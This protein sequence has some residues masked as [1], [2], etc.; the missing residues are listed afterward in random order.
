MY[1]RVI[2]DI[3]SSNVDKIF[4]YIA[5]DDI[6]IGSRVKVPFGNR[7]IEGYV[8]DLSSDTDVD[9]T[10]L[11]HISEILDSYSII[12]DEQMQ[13][14]AFMKEKYNDGYSDTFR[15]FLPSEVRN[16]KVN[17]IF[18]SKSALSTNLSIEYMLNSLKKNASSMKNAL[19][20][21]SENG[22]INT[23]ILNKKFGY[24]AIKKLVQL[25]YIKQFIE[26]IDRIP[27]KNITKKQDNE[28]VLSERQKY[29]IDT[30]I[31]N[32]SNSFLIH[33]ITGSGKTEVY[34]NVIE[35]VRKI[36]KTAIMLVPEISL[37]PQV[38]MLFRNR[39]G[40][41][42]AII[43]SGL[44]SG[45]RYD[46]W[47]R[48]L[49]GRANIVVGAR[50]AIFAPLTNLGIIIID[51]EHDS[52]YVS[53]TNP[54][55][56]TSEIA[57][58]RR[59]YNNATLVLG[60]ATPSIVSYHKAIEGDYYLL[61]MKERV[62]GKKM[63]PINIVDMGM[64]LR[65]GNPDIFSNALKIS[66]EKCLNEGNQ[67]I[68]FLN[69]R[70]YASFMQCRECG[71]VAKCPDCDVSLVYHK[72][73][74]SLKCHFCNN[75]FKVFDTCP[76]C[77]SSSIKTGAIGTQRVVDELNKLFPN[78]KVL[79]MDND[80]TSTKD[81][82]EIILSKFRN[83]EAQ[84]LVGTQMVAKGHDF[85]S[86]TLV[87]II[88]TDNS[89]H[90]SSYTATEKTFSLLIQVA[91][92]AGRADKQG[93]IILQTY[94]P[95]HY[96]YRLAAM[97]DYLAFYKKEINIREVTKYP[98]FSKI[99]RIL[100]TSYNDELAINQLKVYYKYMLTLKDENPNA[101]IYLNKMKSPVSKIKGKLR[102][103]ILMRLKPEFEDKI[104][105]NIFNFDSNNRI[106]NVLTFIEINPQN[107]S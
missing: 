25:G 66:L 15:L 105:S 90:Q 46:E 85:P 45:E 36:G 4:D 60:S 21:L 6:K 26:K 75:R 32:P 81:A 48:I 22:E 5:P 101:F 13:I 97:Y 19:I 51:E 58:L 14:A 91:G 63:P 42:V 92:R 24:S 52:S 64:E 34:M 30:I 35:N 20:Y 62:N 78:V 12:T 28:V 102:Y 96:V 44:S 50:S 82:H 53:E 33:G 99:V 54:R 94:S 95:R 86:V 2:V 87:G 9:K 107:L 74:E 84:V 68:L 56:I 40:D 83:K 7:N 67:A 77:G 29:V 70:G 88:E 37:T 106:R 47:K 71:W 3:A 10:K 80:T 38:L 61:E 89:L 100:F 103:Q 55:Y 23:S 57:E 49:T 104:I 41:D 93:E 17:E 43:H 73:E 18:I 59:K 79:R 39:F 31:S 27:Y 11:K 1:A 69:R 8:V 72:A 98:P 65:L 16:G 76:E